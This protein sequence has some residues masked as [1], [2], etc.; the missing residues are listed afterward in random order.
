MLTS[1]LLWNQQG[2]PCEG[3]VLL[4]F[5]RQH[6]S[7]VKGRRTSLPGDWHQRSIQGPLKEQT[8]LPFGENP[9]HSWKRSAPAS[10]CQRLPEGKWAEEMHLGASSHEHPRCAL[11]TKIDQLCIGSFDSLGGWVSFGCVPSSNLLF[12]HPWSCKEHRL[13]SLS[14]RKGRKQL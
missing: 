3:K 6:C 12:K 8:L 9:F 13:E 4:V 14:T 1:S 5:I 2:G 7:D 11:C 10:P